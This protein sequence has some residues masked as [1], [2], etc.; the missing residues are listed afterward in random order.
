MVVAKLIA[1]RAAIAHRVGKR[2]GVVEASAHLFYGSV[3]FTEFHEGVTLYGVAALTLGVASIV[4]VFFRG[5][6]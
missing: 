6:E 4:A 5:D 2:V 3:V 1:I